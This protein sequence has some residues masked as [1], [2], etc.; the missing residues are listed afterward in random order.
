MMELTTRAV[1]AG[2]RGGGRGIFAG[3][4]ATGGV[5]DCWRNCGFGVKG[6]VGGFPLDARCMARWMR[7]QSELGCGM[8]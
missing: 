2:G 8:R 4:A 1:G 3:G 7:P 5:G 6:D